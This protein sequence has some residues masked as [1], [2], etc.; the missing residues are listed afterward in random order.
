MREKNEFLK[1]Y[2]DF[3]SEQKRLDSKTTRAY[4]NDLLQFSEYFP[5]KNWDKITGNDLEEYIIFLNKMYKVKT[6]KRKLASIKAFFRYLEYKD[7]ILINPFNKVRFHLREP[8]TLPKTIP[9]PI[10]EQL[11]RTIYLQ[12]ESGQTPCKRK[13]ALRD[14]AICELL[15]ATGMRI[16]ELCNL[17]PASI[18]FIDH[19]ILIYGKGSKE[20]KI[21]IGNPEVIAVL[22]RYKNN[23]EQ[24]ISQCNHFFVNPCGTPL[25]DQTV[26]RMLNHYVKL[27]CIDQRITPHMFRHTFA[28]GLLDADVDIRYIQK[29]LGHSSIHTTEIYTHVTMAKQKDILTNKHPRNMLHVR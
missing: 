14:A 12:I 29:M 18:D 17:T 2:R 4:N 3:C 21:Q 1:K 23:F 22:M 27:A 28:S 20:R 10:I 15:F 6:V 24:Q 16:S 26:R 13:K 8:I 19:S 5:T 25:S 7:E 11:F 9:L